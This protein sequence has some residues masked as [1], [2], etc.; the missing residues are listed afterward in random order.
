MNYRKAV[1][2]LL[3]CIVISV[4]LSAGCCYIPEDNSSTTPSVQTSNAVTVT[5]NPGVPTS[6][7]VATTTVPPATPPL[8]TPVPPSTTQA[9]LPDENK[10]PF[11]IQLEKL[12]KLYEEDPEGTISQYRGIR[13]TVRNVRIEDMS[14]LY[15]GQTDDWY[16]INGLIKFRP[17]FV[18]Y[19]NDVKVNHVIDVEGRVSRIQANILVLEECSFTVTD[20]SEGI[21]RPYYGDSIYIY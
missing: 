3:G 1:W 2:T 19:L 10:E 11:E 15:K 14:L 9:G 4:S 5:P 20:D 7:P 18:E 6:S 13:L 16:V 17:E 21:E 8:T 12:Q